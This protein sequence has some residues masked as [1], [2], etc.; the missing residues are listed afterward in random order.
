MMMPAA[1]VARL[2]DD[3]RRPFAAG[4]H[5]ARAPQRHP[6]AAGPR[7]R[8]LRLLVQLHHPHHPTV[9]LK[10]VAEERERPQLGAL[11]H[12]AALERRY[13]V[14]LEVQ[15]AEV[16]RVAEH[17]LGNVGE[18]VAREM[19]LEEG[20]EPVERVRPEELEQVVG[21]P[22]RR[23]VA[24]VGEDATRYEVDEVVLERETNEVVEAL[25]GVRVD[26]PH[27]VAVEVED[28]KAAHVYE[29]ISE[30]RFN[31]VFAEIQNLEVS[32]SNA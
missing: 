17:V 9:A 5:P 23:H 28:A 12:D 25:E 11:W 26:E 21:E 4:V 27:S 13:L 14:V 1:V 22:E 19:K 15:M 8:L 30:D 20:S 10:R 32:I 6:A 18:P 16:R 7:P 31:I 2:D 3:R 29:R 24:E